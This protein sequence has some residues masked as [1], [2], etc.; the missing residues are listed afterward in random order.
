[1]KKC[2]FVFALIALMWS[3][4]EKSPRTV[5]DFNFGWKF[6]L[7]Q[8]STCSETAFD[9]S[10]WRELHLPHD[11]AIEGEF[12]KDNPAT[13]YGGALP[14]GFGWYRKHFV[15][16]QGGKRCFLEFDGVY[17]NSTVYINGQIVG[18]R[19]YGYSSFSYEITDFLAP[20]GQ[21]NVVAVSCDNTKQ[22]NSRWYS[23]SGIYRD[24]RMVVV[25]DAHIA[26]SGIYVT[27]PSITDEKA[28][29]KVVAE[30]EN[31]GQNDHLCYEILDEE[32]KSVASS[33]HGELEIENPVLWSDKNPYQY[34]LVASIRNGNELV[35]RYEQKFGVRYISYD[36]EKGFFLNGKPFKFQGVCLH[37]D[38]GCIGSAVHRR[39][40][41]REL[42]I[43]KD[44]GVNSIRTSH[45]PPA[46]QLLELCDQMGLLVM[47]EAFDM[48]KRNKTKYDYSLY[49]QKW[50]EKDLSDF[51]KR[52]R[53]HPSIVMWSIGNEVIEQYERETVD[54]LTPEEANY[55]LNFVRAENAG[56]P[57]ED[58][59]YILLTR[60]L[61]SIVRQN[62]STRL[63]AAGC[64]Y[65]DK[66]NFLYASDALDVIGA[67][68]NIGQY[69]SLKVWYPGKMYLGSETV[70]TLNT[71]GVYYPHSDSTGKY[72]EVNQQTCY[73]E[74]CAPWGATAEWGWVTIKGREFMAGTFVWTGFDY[75]G[76]P[77]PFNWP[78]RSSYFGIVDLAGFPK[79][80]FWMYQSEWTDKTVLHLLPHWNWEKGDLIDVWAY[81]SNADEVELFLNGKSLGK[82]TKEGNR[83]H[84]LWQNVQFE[85]GKLEAVSYKDGKEVARDCRVTSG[86]PVDIKLT[87]DREV[88]SADGYDLSYVSIDAVD[89][90]GN[91]VPTADGMLEF[92]VEGA[93]ELY[94]VDNGNPIDTLCMKGS[95]KPLFKGKALAVIRSLKDQK[96]S[97]QL[98]VKAYDKQY[99]IVI[100]TK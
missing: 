51:V 60:H 34:T 22:P 61:A 84:A 99:G 87:A 41:E 92:S 58:N 21:D 20:E 31:M 1:M 70:S 14:G 74:K 63:V 81:Y 91:S 89:A 54:D 46:P 3:C 64:N 26:Y 18:S 78:S 10:S 85:P 53:N 97:A 50:H 49:F 44:M 67:N 76:E 82:S 12:S 32:G 35:D 33:T 38:M 100:K 79:D 77:T 86:A 69:D 56:K 59:S 8:D 30:T 48:W 27:T 98:K 73:D 57:S 28:V 96:G 39:A 11:W 45:N 71:R 16:P 66:N 36:P 13:P 29:V 7:T 19:P 55:L 37:H 25:N 4:A 65:V 90:D 62:D 17:M 9:D 80:A 52:D 15:T 93:G 6:C 47:D 83:L 88:I 43:M 5:Q 24:V 2:A 42:Q 75:L 95:V 23:G 68:Y 40:L 94:G 72:N